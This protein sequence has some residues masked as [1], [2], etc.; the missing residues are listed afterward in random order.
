MSPRHPS[1]CVSALPVEGPDA[2]ASQP[3]RDDTLELVD[4]PLARPVELN[5]LLAA[6]KFE[7]LVVAGHT[8]PR[9][10]LVE[11]IDLRRLEPQ[12]LRS[13]RAKHEAKGGRDL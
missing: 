1:F 3:F 4:Q 9:Q 11:G 12:E 6:V 7:E 2:S 5:E 8:S 10:T 13:A